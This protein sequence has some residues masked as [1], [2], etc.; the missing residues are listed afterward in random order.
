MSQNSFSIQKIQ[1]PEL[2]GVGISVVY[3]FLTIAGM[4][5]AATRVSLDKI[6]S[7]EI[8][9][10]L[11]KHVCNGCESTS[12]LPAYASTATHGKAASG[13]DYELLR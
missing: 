3:R 2:P 5:T 6:M 10:V 7:V 4:G 1:C 9:L 11:F 12:F 13:F 8:L